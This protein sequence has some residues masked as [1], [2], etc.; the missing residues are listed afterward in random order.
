M[1]QTRDRRSS[2]RLSSGGLREVSTVHEDAHAVD[3][4][5]LTQLRREM[6]QLLLQRREAL[7]K[8]F[9]EELDELRSTGIEPALELEERAQ[10]AR[11]T[12]IFARLDDRRERQIKEIDD[13]LERIALGTYGICERC[14]KPIPPT[15]LRAMPTAR[16]HVQCA[17][18]EEEG[19]RL[20]TEGEEHLSAGGAETLVAAGREE[21]PPE[22]LEVEARTEQVPPDISAFTDEEIEEY[23]RQ[24]LT[25]DG[26]VDLDELQVT[27]R[28]GVM[29]L[30]GALPTEEQH[31]I[32]LRY[33]TD[34]AGIQ[35]IVDRLVIDE[36]AW[37]REDRT[38]PPVDEEP[39]SGTVSG[40]LEDV[41]E[42]DQENRDFSPPTGPV[43]E[44]V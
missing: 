5:E 19:P 29:Y 15:R 40:A 24:L 13:A 11:D 41:I 23:I 32:L 25:E 42:T 17:S 33:V 28:S 30:D 39:P 34:V 20:M 16:F 2:P 26:R 9:T 43:Q 7:L 44:D 18:E 37:E 14:G 1:A 4:D 27:C 6:A 35:E 21:E 36:L 12:R 8:E 38:E 31:Q 22:D 3:E 10:K